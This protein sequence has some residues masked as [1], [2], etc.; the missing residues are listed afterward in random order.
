[1]C[2]CISYNRPDL[3]LA[4]GR[5]EVILPAPPQ[6]TDKPNGICVDAC[7]AD[8]IRMLWSHGVETKGCCCGHNRGGPSVVIAKQCD[9]DMVKRLLSEHDGRGWDVFQWRLIKC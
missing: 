8:A 6:I 1:M 2:D 4:D 5:P 7:I 9:G 3:C